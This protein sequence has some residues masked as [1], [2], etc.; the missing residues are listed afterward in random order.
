M[1]DNKDEEM[2]EDKDFY[3]RL[4]PVENVSTSSK[5]KQA[6]ILSSLITGISNFR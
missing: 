3:S 6:S 1:F 4:I 5:Q 2:F